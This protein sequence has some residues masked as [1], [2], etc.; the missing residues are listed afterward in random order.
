[1]VLRCKGTTSGY[2]DLPVELYLLLDEF[3]SFLEQRSTEV[4][5]HCSRLIQA[6]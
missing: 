2:S 4:G 5:D 6:R 3:F 1:M